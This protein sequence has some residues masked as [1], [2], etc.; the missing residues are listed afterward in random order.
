MDAHT[1]SAAVWR[2]RARTPAAIEARAHPPPEDPLITAQVAEPEAALMSTAAQAQAGAPR[3]LAHALEAAG[4]TMSAPYGSSVSAPTRDTPSSYQQRN[5]RSSPPAPKPNPH[6]PAP[7]Q[8]SRTRQGAILTTGPAALTCSFADHTFTVNQ[9]CNCPRITTREVRSLEAAAPLDI[10]LV[11]AGRSVLER[12]A[13]QLV[14]QGCYAARQG[15]SL[16]ICMSNPNVAAFPAGWR[17][18]H[19]TRITS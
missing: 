9:W 6:P 19:G 17:P 10:N 13:P 15:L 14:W 3:N 1:C 7:R 18:T 2:Q 11:Q 12:L 8:R 16:V 5:A 4:V